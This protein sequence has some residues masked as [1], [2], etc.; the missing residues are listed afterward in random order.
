MQIFPIK[1]GGPGRLSASLS[2]GCAQD[3]CTPPGAL[4]FDAVGLSG[5]T[6]IHAV[7]CVEQNRDVVLDD[8]PSGFEVDPEVLMHRR[9]VRSFRNPSRPICSAVS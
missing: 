2:H 4:P 8:V 6:F 9:T 1:D 3:S 5:N 7:Q